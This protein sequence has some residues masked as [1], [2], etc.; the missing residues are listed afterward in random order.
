MKAESNSLP[1]VASNATL[2]VISASALAEAEIPTLP[3]CENLWIGGPR[4]EKRHAPELGSR[5]DRNRENIAAIEEVPDFA[6]PIQNATNWRLGRNTIDSGW[7]LINAFV[8]LKTFIKA[9]P[10]ILSSAE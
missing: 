4:N 2:I 7:R 8:F 1:D 6:V 5:K 9:L 3:I 10:V